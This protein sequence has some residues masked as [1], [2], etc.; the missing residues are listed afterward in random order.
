MNKHNRRRFLK[1]M[2]AAGVM[3]P[4]AAI[5]EVAL[6]GEQQPAAPTAAQAFTDLGRARFGKHLNEG[7]L[8]TMQ[9][10][11]AGNVRLGDLIQR[12]PL[13]PT[14]EPATVFFADAE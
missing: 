1:T 10:D 3:A 13:D 4:A 6:A 5:P 9:T 11:I 7:Q 8:K 12:S 2:A 14:E